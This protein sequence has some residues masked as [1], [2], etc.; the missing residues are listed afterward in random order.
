[1]HELD[2]V[3]AVVVVHAAHELAP[4]RDAIVAVDQRVAR[5]E[6]AARVDGRVRGDDRAD[7]AAGE[8]EIPVDPDRRAGAGVVVPPARDAGPQ[9]AVFDRQVP[10]PK[11]LED[12]ARSHWAERIYDAAPVRSRP[13]VGPVYTSAH[14]PKAGQRH[15]TVPECALTCDEGG[16]A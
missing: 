8:L 10:E 5:H 6:P 12:R 4:E 16:T 14:K 2:Y 9:D 15:A 3:F 13:Q 7:A 1:V 11:R